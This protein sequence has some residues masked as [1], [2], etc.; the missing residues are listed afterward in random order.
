MN[1]C[2]HCGAPV[3]VPDAEFCARCGKP[4]A[5]ADAHKKTPF[6]PYSCPFCG[7]PIELG[8]SHCAYCKMP[9]FHDPTAPMTGTCAMCG[10]PAP[11]GESYCLDCREVLH[12]MEHSDVEDAGSQTHPCADCG[13]TVW[14]G[15]EYC[16]DCKEKR[17]RAEARAK[18]ARR[19]CWHC[20]SETETR[21]HYC[22]SCRQTHQFFP[23]HAFAGLF[24]SRKF[25]NVTVS[26]TVWLL[27]ACLIV[28]FFVK[29]YRNAP[30][31]K[32]QNTEYQQMTAM[33]GNLTFEYPKKFEATFTNQSTLDGQTATPS[34]SYTFDA[35][36]ATMTVTV[37]GVQP[38]Q[39]DM[40]ALYEKAVQACSSTPET[41]QMCADWY[42]FYWISP[43]GEIYSYEYGTLADGWYY[44]LHFEFD[45]Y[46]RSEYSGYWTEL[47]NRFHPYPDGQVPESATS[48]VIV[49]KFESERVTAPSYNKNYV[50]FSYPE[51]FYLVVNQPDKC[52]TFNPYYYTA[53][54]GTPDNSAR[55]RIEVRDRTYPS[56]QS[57]LETAPHAAEFVGTACTVTVKDKAIDRYYFCCDADGQDLSLFEK[58]IITDKYEYI[59]EFIYPTSQKYAYQDYI[60]QMHENFSIN[61]V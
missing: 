4:L 59:L 48:P 10:K 2:S 54:A 38:S 16:P 9:L 41:S 37:T 40:V 14:I 11:A 6:I 56:T 34:I 39:A 43:S 1:T 26:V 49:P 22:A 47:K 12:D 23:N 8:D 29:E 57:A 31:I 24:S 19:V 58:C 53:M 15:A 17:R 30:I 33:I 55:L 3:S 36:Y 5:R 61:G 7:A 50:R 35:I 42:E 18:K 60:D 25:W 28:H 46:L 52:T 13:K 45:K 32:A 44:Q 51:H 27:T 20:G 21:G